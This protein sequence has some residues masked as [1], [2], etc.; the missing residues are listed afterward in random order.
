MS[1]DSLV[2]TVLEW[3]DGTEAKNAELST[4]IK[5]VLPVKEEDTDKVEHEEYTRRYEKTH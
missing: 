1:W 5:N 3:K 2:H 4:Q